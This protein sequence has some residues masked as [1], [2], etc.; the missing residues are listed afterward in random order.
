LLRSDFVDAMDSARRALQGAPG[1]E[2]DFLV[3][4]SRAGIAFADGGDADAWRLLRQAF[5]DPPGTLPG[6]RRLAFA[7]DLVSA[8]DPSSGSEARWILGFALADVRGDLRS[9]LGKASRRAPRN[10]A[11]AYASALDALDRG[12]WQEARRDARRACD[13][14]LR[15][16]CTLLPGLR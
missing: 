13:F 6:G 2:A 7:R 16:G 5:S 8:K 15:D 11:I 4:Y 12:Q 9:E 10:P 14:G 1:Q 3:A